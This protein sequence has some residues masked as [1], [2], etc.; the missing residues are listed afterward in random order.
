MR[1]ARRL[2]F[3][4]NFICASLVAILLVGPADA[5][6]KEP[7]TR[8]QPPRSIQE[9]LRFGEA[10][11]EWAARRGVVMQVSDAVLDAPAGDASD[12]AGPKRF[13]MGAG[14]SFISGF[15]PPCFI[16]YIGGGGSGQPQ[17]C[18]WHASNNAP[19]TSTQPTIIDLNPFSGNQHLHFEFDPGQNVGAP[20]NWAFTDNIPNPPPNGVMSLTLQ[21]NIN[22]LGGLNEYHIHPQASGQGPA[23]LMI[24]LPTGEILAFEDLDPDDGVIDGFFTG[25]DW[26]PGE[27]KQVG[28]CVDN[29]NNRVRYFY[30]GDLV[31][32]SGAGD[33]GQDTGVFGA[34]TIESLV[35][36]YD[37]NQIGSTKM[38]VDDVL[39]EPDN[40]L[41]PTGACW[42]RPGGRRSGPW[43]KRSPSACP[44]AMMTGES[45]S[46]Y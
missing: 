26:V 21:L 13:R 28:L 17:N 20:R 15:E 42:A 14:D 27:Y 36:L 30:D 12:K 24:F 7:K 34:T 32:S 9:A 29:L 41:Q 18:N 44:T 22:E 1:T 35:I 16:G 43:D 4:L 10:I 25:F 45:S 2:R 5:Q 40:C 3:D 19:T 11:P 39:I 38:D 33:C 37:D 46:G 6:Q 8:R 23:A 31:Y